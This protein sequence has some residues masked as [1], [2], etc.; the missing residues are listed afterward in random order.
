MKGL[1]KAAIREDDPV[2]C[3]ED[4]AL[5]GDREPIP[6]GDHVVPLGS[7]AVKRAGDDVT[8]VAISGAVSVALRA[9]E[10]LSAEGISV[11]VV[12]PRSLVP[13][14]V[15]TILGSVARTGRLVVVDPAHRTCSAASEIAAIAAEEAFWDLR[16]PVV[17]VTTP[18]TQIPFSPALLSSLLP[19]VDAVV[20]AVRRVL[21]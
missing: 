20:S 9:A 4:Q 21:G 8:V 5:W 7:A 13:L 2:L 6:D 3:F 17:R 15:P 14:D 10:A 18:D 12:D 19:D 11:E 16:A 1:L